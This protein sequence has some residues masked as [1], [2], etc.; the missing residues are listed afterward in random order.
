MALSGPQSARSI[1][2]KIYDAM[3]QLIR[4]PLSGPPV[5]D[6]QLG[7][8]GY[9]YILAGKYLVFYHLLGDMVAIYYIPYPQLLKTTFFSKHI[10]IQSVS[11]KWAV[12]SSCY[13]AEISV[14]WGFFEIIILFILR[15]FPGAPPP[16]TGFPYVAYLVPDRPVA[17]ARAGLSAGAAHR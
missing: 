17:P 2:D 16:H 8:T 11:S 4:F 15:P 13:L 12:N 14:N 9:R 10:E 1:T 3:E 7:D 6:N 5:H